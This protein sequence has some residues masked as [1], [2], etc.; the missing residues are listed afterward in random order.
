MESDKNLKENQKIE[1][2]IEQLQK[3]PSQ[4][5]LAHALTVFRRRMNEGGEL[6]PAVDQ[7]A[8]TGALKMRVLRTEDGKE[9]FLA[10][11]GFEEQRKDSNPIMSG[12]TAEIRQLF[13]M[14]LGEPNIEGII[15]NP[16]NRTLMLDKNL[17]RII[18]GVNA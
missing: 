18:M 8:G 1:A 17:I 3:V 7:D 12:F 2:A 9:W 6:I 14:A 13:V 10:Y 11:T 4:E 15:I 5:T 16:W